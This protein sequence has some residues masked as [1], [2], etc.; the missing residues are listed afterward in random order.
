MGMLC[1]QRAR[2]R[3]LEH[4]IGRVTGTRILALSERFINKQKRPAG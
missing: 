1:V 3:T 2:G 4:V